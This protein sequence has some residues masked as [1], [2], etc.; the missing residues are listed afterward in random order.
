MNPKD[1]E[2]EKLEIV[3]NPGGYR[4][5]YNGDDLNVVVDATCSGEGILRSGN[6]QTFHTKISLYPQYAGYLWGIYDHLFAKLWEKTDHRNPSQLK[7][8]FELHNNNQICCSFTSITPLTSMGNS[9]AFNK[10]K[11]CI[12]GFS[13][14]NHLIYAIAK[15]LS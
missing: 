13:T 15:P 5:K 11:I 3:R 10:L 6:G 7:M 2:L 9:R 8:L 14:G 12:F 4:I 1:V